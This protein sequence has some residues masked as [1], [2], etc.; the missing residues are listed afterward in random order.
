[1]LCIIFSAYTETEND[2]SLQLV[3]FGGDLNLGGGNSSLDFF[4]I[5]YE[6][7]GNL[8]GFRFSPLSLKS[9]FFGRQAN[10]NSVS[11]MTFLSLDVYYNLLNNDNH[12]IGPYFSVN[13]LSIIDWNGIDPQF[14]TISLG[15][16]YIAKLDMYSFIGINYFAEYEIAYR[17]NEIFGHHFYLGYKVDLL[18]LIVFFSGRSNSSNR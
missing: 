16:K 12:L 17:Y 18:S 7:F 4:N 15:V 5:Y 10:T 13:Y 9:Y 3:S 8:L 6:I 1:M 14:V 2:F 11:E